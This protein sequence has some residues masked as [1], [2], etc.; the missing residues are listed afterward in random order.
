MTKSNVRTASNVRFNDF[1]RWIKCF[2]VARKDICEQLC[3]SMSSN[4]L[5]FDVPQKRPLG[6]QLGRSKRDCNPRVKRNSLTIL[7]QHVHLGLLKN[8]PLD[9]KCGRPKTLESSS[10][11][12][13][14]RCMRVA[15]KGWNHVASQQGVRWLGNRDLAPC[16]SRDRNYECASS[17]FC[18]RK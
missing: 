6:G 4:V 18:V 12:Q 5:P 8:E 15:R 9:G 14:C 1:N 11:T 7:L 2:C 3:H 17:C 10:G 16:T 13:N